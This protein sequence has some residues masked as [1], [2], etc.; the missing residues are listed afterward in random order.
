VKIVVVHCHPV[1]ESYGAALRD[2]VLG[3]LAAKGHD[4][5]LLDLYAMGFD[6]VMTG[7]ERRAYNDGPPADP[8]LSE[9]IEAL[10]W[11]EG[12]ILVY[13]TWWNAMPAM[14]KGW[15]DRVWAVDVAFRLA[16]DG[17]KI[18]PNMRNI[19]LLG[20]VTTGGAPRWTSWLMGQPG[21]RI[22]MR[23]IRALCSP[24]ARTFFLVHY[25]IDASTP[26]SRA[27]FV[28]RVRARIAR[29]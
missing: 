11:A 20:V 22:I 12:L 5:R 4:T 24:A 3:A 2:V 29:I 15:F 23:A 14:L 8:A 13:P 21:R 18:I 28:D 25:E 9:H 10:R 16:P 1:A 7:D 17:G 26:A 27:A 6:P 19:G